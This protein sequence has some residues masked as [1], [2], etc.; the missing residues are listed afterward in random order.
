MAEEDK[1]KTAFFTRECVFCYQ[2]MPFSLKNAGATYQ[3]LV[4]KVFHD[5][6]GRNL[7]AYV[8]D[9]VIKI[10]F[11]EEMLAEI[12]ETFERVLQ[13]AELNYSALEKFIL[14]LALTKPEKSGRLAKWAINLLSE[15]PIES[16]KIRVMAPQYKLIREILYRRSF[17]IPLLRCIAS[18]QTDNIVKEIYKGSSGFNVE[19]YLMVVKVTK[20]GYHWPSM[21]RDATKVIQDCEKCKEQ[22][23]IRKAAEKDAITAGN[24]CKGLKVT[25]S[26]SPIT[27]HME[28]MNHIEKQLTRSQQ[29]WVDDL[30]QVLWGKAKEVTKW[31]ERKEVASIEEAYYKNKLCR[32]YDERSS[33]STYKI[34]DFILLSQNNAG[35]P[36]VWQGPHMISE[37]YEGKLYKIIDASDHSLTQMAK[38]ISLRKF[39]M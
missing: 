31:K 25:Q 4:D 37:V 6:I 36:Q 15:D 22:S 7:E 17:Y 1:D 19:P 5:Q 16:K 26:F 12:K 18:S 8:D 24:R 39:Y 35:N 32:Y 28:I 10:T 23:A 3:R 30:A 13:G 38:G 34:R 2:K 27:E 11:K 33:H 14:A 21:H 20:Q 29:G 9:M